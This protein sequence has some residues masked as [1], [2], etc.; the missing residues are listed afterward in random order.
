MVKRSQHSSE[1]R[2]EPQRDGQG[3]DGSKTSEQPARPAARKPYQRPVVQK[4]KSVAEATLYSGSGN[5][6]TL[7]G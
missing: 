6:G 2:P 1:L 7:V 5:T 3:G 4:R